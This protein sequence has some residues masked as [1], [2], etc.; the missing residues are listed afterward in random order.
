MDSNIV[1]KNFKLNTEGAFSITKPYESAQIIFLVQNFI[2][3]NIHNKII[4][5]GTACMGGDVVKFSKYFKYVNA[6]EI[7]EEN[8]NLLIE[9]CKIFNCQNVNLFNQ[10]YTEIY[11]KLKQDIIYLDPP[12][13]GPGYK[14]KE[15]IVLK[16]GDF[17][18]WKLI[19]IIKSKNLSKYIFI[20]APSNVCLDNL[21][22][23][24]I[25]VV[26]NK[27]KSPSF[28]LICIRNI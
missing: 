22:Y 8:F 13:T 28:K 3:E 1:L 24:S 16:L 2:Q 25:H 27:S 23:D 12:W 10:D 15:S 17:E 11:E 21:E 18:I 4:T 6:V 5:D 7:L 14:S 20:K 26:Y 9:N 19:N